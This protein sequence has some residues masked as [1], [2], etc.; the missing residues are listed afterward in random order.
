MISDVSPLTERQF[1]LV[2]FMG[3]YLPTDGEF[4]TPPVPILIHLYG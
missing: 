1:L 3:I 2:G 4:G